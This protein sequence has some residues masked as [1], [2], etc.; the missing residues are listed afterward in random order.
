MQP[1]EQQQWLTLHLLYGA[2]RA[3]WRA[4]LASFPSPAAILEASPEQWHAAGIDPAN[5]RRVPG[6]ATRKQALCLQQ[7]LQRL[8]VELVPLTAPGYPPLLAQIPDPPPL[9][10]VRGDARYLRRPALA[11]V[12]SRKPG[13]AGIRAAAEFTAAAVAQELVVVSGLA[14]GIDGRAHQAALDNQ[15][16]TVAVLATGVDYCYPRRHQAM[17]AEIIRR[18]ALV[19]EALPGSEPLPARFPQRNRIISGLSLGVLVV[20]AAQRSGSLITARFAL[21]QNREVFALP[22]SIYYGGGAGCNSL[23]RDGATLVTCADDIFAELGMLCQAQ[24][25]LQ[26]DTVVELPPELLAVYALVG[27]EPVSADGLGALLGIGTPGI[28]AA[29]VELQLRGMVR[30]E[31]G[32]FLRT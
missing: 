22:H 20:E 25:A 28:L 11:V 26:E 21:E 7:Q 9:L 31:A 6:A 24:H 4:L 1:E 12:G 2:R 8:Q 29:L 5:R 30:V 17:A 32:Q 23:L 19:S 18:G 15:G 13:S 16:A 27:F 10:Y 3:L 14:L